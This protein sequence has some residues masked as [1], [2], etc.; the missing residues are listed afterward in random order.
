MAENSDGGGGINPAMVFHELGKLASS[1]QAI[2]RDSDNNRATIIRELDNLKADTGKQF[3]QIIKQIDVHSRD[4]DARFAAE[5]IENDA[6]GARITAESKS[7]DRR[8]KVLEGWRLYVAGALA[9]LV[10]IIGLLKWG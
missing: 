8:L 10:F 2:I 9:V 3:D 5:K 6:L 1:L 4:D 7:V